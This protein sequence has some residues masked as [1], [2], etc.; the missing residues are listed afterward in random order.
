MLISEKDIYNIIEGNTTEDII[1]RNLELRPET[2]SKFICGLANKNGGYILIG[3]E[4]CNGDLIIKE[5]SKRWYECYD[6]ANIMKK[7]K[8]NID[9]SIVIKY[10]FETINNSHIFVIYVK[11]S[12][13]RVLLSGR[14]YIYTNND[15][16]ESKASDFVG[17]KTLFISYKES[18][19]PI[20]DI[21]EEKVKEILKNRIKISRYTELEYKDS[22]R[23]FMDKIEEHDFV[24][25]IVSDSYLKSQA[26]MYE[27]GN[28]INHKNYK[29][30]LLFVVVSESERKYY[31]TSGPEK[32]GPDV[33]QGACKMLDYVEYWK[34]KYDELNNKILEIGSLEATIYAAEDLKIIGRIF[35]NDIGQFMKILAD[36]NGKSFEELY[37]NNFDELIKYLK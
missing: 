30:R 22:F 19:K 13:I 17:P 20:A 37:K 33:Y 8:N 9:D 36:E 1:S 4:K 35:N 26:C 3:V 28:V 15:V 16:E 10:G 24:L 18:D 21:I 25:T 2:L 32:I 12:D 5:G 7:V 34:K 23:E 27:V 11:S 29:K 31:G 14:Y 6:F